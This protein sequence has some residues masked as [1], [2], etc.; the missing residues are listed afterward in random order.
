V[1]TLILYG[2]GRNALDTLIKIDANFKSCGFWHEPKRKW[3]Q[4]S[5]RYVVRFHQLTAHQIAH[6]R[7]IAEW[8]PNIYK[9][10]LL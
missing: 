2:S 1:R 7:N 5:P 8:N 4:L 3:W 6:A 9:I 10:E